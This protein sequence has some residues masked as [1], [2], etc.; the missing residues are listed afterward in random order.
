ERYDVGFQPGSHF[1]SMNGLNTYLRF[2]FTYY[3]SGDLVE[4]V[5]RLARAMD[6]AG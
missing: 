5:Q 3:D 6:A 1:S 2:C 4:G